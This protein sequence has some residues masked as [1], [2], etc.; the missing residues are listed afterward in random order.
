MILAKLLGR[1]MP[2]T[3]TL[4]EGEKGLLFNHKQ[5]IRVL[6]SGRHKFAQLGA[7]YS[8][9]RID[10]KKCN[11]WQYSED[12]LFLL[13]KYPQAFEEHALLLA[14]QP[15]QIALV[16]K[17][18]ILLTVLPPSIEAYI[19]LDGQALH[20]EYLDI[21]DKTLIDS[22]LLADL[23]HSGEYYSL[24]NHGLIAETTVPQEHV[25]LQFVDDNF[26]QTLTTG[27]YAWWALNSEI[28]VTSV[29]LRLQNMEIT[30]QEILTKDRVSIRLNLLAT[31][32]VLDAE[33]LVLTVKNHKDFLY[34][35]MQL[36]L[37]TVVATK[38]LDELLADKNLLNSEIKA[39]VLP[40][41]DEYGVALK[42][43]GVKDVIL[44]GEMKDILSK[45]VEA[46]KT[47]EANIIKRRE[48][49]QATRSLHNTAK[50]ME[51][52]PVLLRLK[53]LES[54]EKITA[55]IGSLNVYGGL[56]GVMN[57]LV[58]LRS[59]TKT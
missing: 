57:G 56:D 21:T 16:Y 46:Q 50:V 29:D 5:F 26:A 4:A 11:Y 7:D 8:L 32:Q 18:G 51:N 54:L 27:R 1:L 30:G 52:N 14:T 2:Q 6:P 45:V 40:I 35:E 42:T 55:Q 24:F 41:A 33:K 59:D 31:W 48:E 37:R 10:S 53:E 25:G 23:K 12:I 17:Q 47:A 58:D 13:K 43:V 34:R 49:T 19:W 22:K 36:A 15:Q 28:K 20:V 44:P 38:T 39:L 9:K 3:F